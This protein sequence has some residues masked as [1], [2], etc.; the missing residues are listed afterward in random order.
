[1]TRD[2]KPLGQKAYGHIGHLPGSRRGPGDHGL[3]EGQARI[4]TDKARDRHDVVIV[5]EKLDGSCV[6]VAKIN[7]ELVALG[8]AG[9]RAISSPFAM[10]HMFHVWATDRWAIFNE[11]LG[12]GERVVGEWLAQAHGTRYDLTGRE[13]W[14][15]FDLMRGV[16]R[17]TVEELRSRTMPLDIRTP[18]TLGTGPTT[19]EAAMKALGPFGHYGAL[20]PAEGAVWRVERKGV[21]DFLGKYVR[22]DKVDG[23]YL[24]S[25]TGGE[26]VWNWKPEPKA[27]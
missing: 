12:E 5:Q 18:A 15:A 1:M 3:S 26:P 21:V 10:H 2:D 8:R 24:D 14:V 4:L 22:P 7:G 9:Y 23:S 13:P 16:Q 6:S 19:I 27:A 20:D 17:V 25:V 11:L